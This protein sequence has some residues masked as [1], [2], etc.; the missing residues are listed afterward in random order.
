MST[1][2]NYDVD[3]CVPVAP[4]VR[5]FMGI[6]MITD[7]IDL[8]GLSYEELNALRKRCVIEM[9]NATD[10]MCD[11]FPVAVINILKRNRIYS[12]SDLV[13]FFHGR[14]VRISGIGKTSM[15]KIRTAI[16][17]ISS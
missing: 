7:N 5:V 12:K 2:E 4:L 17:E 8:S 11:Y 3:P 13:S 16:K 10:W 14:S 6:D 9:E 15:D 1:N